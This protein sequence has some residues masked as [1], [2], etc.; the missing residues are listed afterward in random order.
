MHEKLSK[1]EIKSTV[2]LDSAAGCVESLRGVFDM[3]PLQVF[4]YLMERIDFVMFGADAVVETGGIINKIG[5]YGIA[6]CARAMNKPVYVL[7]ESIKF[8][9]GKVR[10]RARTF[11]KRHFQNI[12]YRKPTF[13]TNTKCVV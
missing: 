9:K 11:E 10:L 1:K 13:Q 5:T 8:V 4:S 3:L 2:I 7:T 12:L 6:L